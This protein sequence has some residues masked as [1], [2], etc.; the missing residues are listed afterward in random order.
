ME[1]TDAGQ[2]LGHSRCGLW[3]VGKQTQNARPTLHRNR[4]TAEALDS[5]H[6]LFLSGLEDAGTKGVSLFDA[7]LDVLTEVV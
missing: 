2:P 6:H 4:E 1:G 3:G 7:A 5:S